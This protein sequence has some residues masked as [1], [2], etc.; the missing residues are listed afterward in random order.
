M[1]HLKTERIGIDGLE[2]REIDFE[3]DV[4]VNK[5]GLFTTTIPEPW[6][7]KLHEA[8]IYSNWNRNRRM[9]FFE[10]RTLEGLNKLIVD[11]LKVLVSKELTDERI[12]LKYMVSTTCSYM[13]DEQGT[14]LPNGF[15]AGD[16]GSGWKGGNVNS[17]AAWPVPY[18]LQ[19][20]VEPCK[21]QTYTFRDGRTK[22]EYVRL[23]EGVDF[24]K[25]SPLHWLDSLTAMAVPKMG[26]MQEIEYTEPVARFFV[27]MVS[28]ICKMNEQIKDF[29]TPEA[30]KEIADKGMKFLEGGNNG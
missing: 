24:E 13:I 7:D 18:G 14:I 27:G 25:R 5:E 8:G 15:W 19:V 9:G 1:G 6:G 29:L 20:Y 21:K 28:S 16:D 30:I 22:V 26:K 2:K 3:Y 23:E 12:V 4:Y 11:N 17:N 10:S